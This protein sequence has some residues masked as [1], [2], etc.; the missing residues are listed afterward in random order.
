MS[1][2]NNLRLWKKS[3]SAQDFL[4]HRDRLIYRSRS[5]L[6]ISLTNPEREFLQCVLDNQGIKDTAEN[7]ADKRYNHSQRQL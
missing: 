7:F 6:P 3:V 1:P 4:L 5:Q 2:P